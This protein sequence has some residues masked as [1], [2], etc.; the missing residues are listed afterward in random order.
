MLI[1]YII[2]YQKSKDDADSVTMII[3]NRNSN[4]EIRKINTYGTYIA[5]RDK[6]CARD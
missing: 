4:T 6:K 2:K 1:T 3:P 5:R